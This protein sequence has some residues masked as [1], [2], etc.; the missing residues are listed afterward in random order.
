MGGAFLPH[1]SNTVHT[2]SFLDGE[3]VLELSGSVGFGGQS[4]PILF[5]FRNIL[6]RDGCR[7]Q[8]SQLENSFGAH[9]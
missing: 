1:K 7:L 2:F 8:Y 9:S 4:V 3:S 5:L 6:S